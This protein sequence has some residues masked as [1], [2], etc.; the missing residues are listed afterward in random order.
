[1][2][3]NPQILSTTPKNYETDV[4]INTSITVDF[5]I[6]L[7]QRYIDGNI[8]LQDNQGNRVDGRYVFRRQTL[9]FIPYNPLQE[10]TTYTFVMVGD[11]NLND[12]KTEGLRSIIGEPLM[13]N[14]TITFVTESTKAIEPPIGKTPASES[15]IR[16]IPTFSWTD[17]E[18]AV[19]YQI[20]ISR[21]NRFDTLVFPTDPTYEVHGTSIDPAI[22]WEDGIYYWKLRSVRDDG[23]TSE[24]STVY[25]FNLDRSEE[26]TIASEDTL[27]IDISYNEG[28]LEL[29]LVEQFPNHLAVD[30]PT[31]LKSIYFR[32]IGQVDSTSLDADS[33]KVYGTHITGDDYEQSHGEVK[34][35]FAIV[36]DDDGTTYIIFT[37]D[38]LP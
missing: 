35:Q 32:V 21:S 25:Q 16:Q 2:A 23:K 14:V 33:F 10:G 31:N 18:G 6:D 30:V 28:L 3:R 26:G 19:A 11:S 13:G 17:V 38:L 36:T 20:M 15:V 29:E 8:Y 1:M 37:P 5:S 4:P 27:P 24:W 12:G 9:T 22:Q 34:G 7:D